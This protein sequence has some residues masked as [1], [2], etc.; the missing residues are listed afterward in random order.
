M[1]AAQFGGS[2]GASSE[3]VDEEIDKEGSDDLGVIGKSRM[4]NGNMSLSLGAVLLGRH[5]NQAARQRIIVED[6]LN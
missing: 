1:N 5:V 6:V 3:T 4:P 2:C